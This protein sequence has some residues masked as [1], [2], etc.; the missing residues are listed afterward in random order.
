MVQT[1][2][3]QAG[4]ACCSVVPGR[5]Q[6]GGS[7]VGSSGPQGTE[8]CLVTQVCGWMPGP[9]VD[10]W[11]KSRR[12]QRPQ[13][14][15]AGGEGGVGGLDSVDVGFKLPISPRP[16]QVTAWIAHLSVTLCASFSPSLR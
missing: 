12:C 16:I 11:W 8:P 2:H 10:Y 15:T 3:L 9:Q 6:Y 4:L 5:V 1:L 14:N 13:N 7:C